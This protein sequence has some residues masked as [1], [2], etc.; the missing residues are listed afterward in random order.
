MTTK[1]KQRMERI[2]KAI[3]SMRGAERGERIRSLLHKTS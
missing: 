1:N 3:G 2:A